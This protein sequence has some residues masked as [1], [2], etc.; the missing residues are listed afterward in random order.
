MAS[1]PLQLS[2]PPAQTSSY[3]TVQFTH[4]LISR[5]NLAGFFS[6]YTF[7]A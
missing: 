3:V 6:S 5:H 7:A 4:W 2:S 1:Y